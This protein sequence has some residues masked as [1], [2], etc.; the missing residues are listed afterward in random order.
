M[1]RTTRAALVERRSIAIAVRLHSALVSL[2]AAPAPTPDPSHA[3]LARPRSASAIPAERPGLSAR[4]R[5]NAR[6]LA[7]A[8]WTRDGTSAPPSERLTWFVDDLGDFIGH[9]NTRARLLFLAC[10]TTITWAGPLLI[11]RLGRLR[12]LSIA[13][14]VRAVHAVEKNPVASLALFA[15]KAIVSIVWYEH[16]DNAREIGWDQRCKRS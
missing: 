7:E 15:A 3:P 1:I 12:S 11:G 10:L 6:A 14:R 4:D 9:L 13:D 16:P 8:L 2:D 5:D